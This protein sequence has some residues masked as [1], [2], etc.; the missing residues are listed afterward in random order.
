MKK[1][2]SL[3]TAGFLALG[4]MG[5]SGLHDAEGVDLVNLQLK[6]SIF[7]WDNDE[8][9]KLK[10]DSD[11]TYYYEFIAT[12]S[13]IT[14]AIDDTGVDGKKAWV[15]TYRGTSDDKLYEGFKDGEGKAVL[16]P[17]KDGDCMPL[18]LEPGATYRIS[19]VSLGGAIECTVKKIADAIPFSLVTKDG[20]IHALQAK[21]ATTFEYSFTKAQEGTL[22]FYLKSGILY[23][24]PDYDDTLPLNK[25]DRDL[26]GSSH[27]A[28]TYWT[29]AYKAQTPYKIVV[30][31]DKDSGEISVEAAY[32]FLITDNILS[33]SQFSD[34][35]LTWEFTSEYAYAE[36]E[37]IYATSKD[38]WGSPDEWAIHNDG[39]GHK[40]C[41]VEVKAGGDFVELKANNG[42]NAR[43]AGLTDGATY[44]LTIKATA[45]SVY[46]KIIAK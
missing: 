43:F 40:Y 25:A 8:S 46:A 3:L 29:F 6:G 13:D 4:L 1:I 17:H 30:E 38:G 9:Y 5:C 35:T 15:T 7:T 20:I 28:D 44:V 41:G 18:K 26:E 31:Y 10:E 34:D 42:S 36:Y 23:Y 21:S 19:I 27:P 32:G 11:G 14:F 37:F 12:N 22:E 39:W 33:G 16:Y 2:F 45:D 24:S